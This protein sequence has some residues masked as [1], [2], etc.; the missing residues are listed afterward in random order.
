MALHH[1]EAQ[2]KAVNNRLYLVATPIGNLADISQRA[3]NTLKQVDVILAE[4][5]RHSK[6]LLQHFGIQTQ[7]IAF[8]EHNEREKTDWVIKQLQ[9]GKNLA[10]ISD[11]GTPLISDPGFYLVRELQKHNLTICPIP[12]PCA[13]TTALSASGLATD[14]FYFAGF[15]PNKAK[16]RQRTLLALAQRTETC[17]TYESGHRI[18]ACLQDMAILLNDRPIVLAKE[19]TKKFETIKSGSAESLALWL[20][21]N[22]SRQKGEFVLLIQG[23]EHTRQTNETFE[24]SLSDLLQSFAA[25][26]PPKVLAK[27]L[28][29]LTGVEKKKIYQQLIENP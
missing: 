1:G 9:S 6:P 10:L 23:H 4:D 3:I 29:E 22:P 15:L 25:H 17:I 7:V 13:L 21:D 5:T 18:L 14:R 8:H 24:L 2:T 27:I 16:A 19:L 26:M 12:G 11:A 20:T 28:A